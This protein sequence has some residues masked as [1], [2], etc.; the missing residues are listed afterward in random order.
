MTKLDA[1]LRR[2]DHAEGIED[3]NKGIVV[4]TPDRIRTTILIADDGN[5]LKQKIFNVM[6]LLKESDIQRL[7]KKS[8]ICEKHDGCLYDTSRRLYVS[9]SNILWM[10]IIQMHHN[11]LVAGHLGD[12]KTIELFS[13]TTGSL[14]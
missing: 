6:C 5:I 4:I 2:E 8:T 14:E 11:S 1:L 10:E 13:A 3:D 7:C 12:E 9:D